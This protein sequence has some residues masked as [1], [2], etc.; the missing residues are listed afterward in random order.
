MKSEEHKIQVAVV[1]WAEQMRVLCPDLWMLYANPNGG[2][3]NPITGAMLK[4]EGTRR[5]IPDL[6]LAV[7]RHGFHGLYLEMK[8]SKGILSRDQK[9]WIEAL[10][11]QV[12]RVEV[13]RSVAEAIEVFRDYLDLKDLRQVK[14]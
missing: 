6:F 7:A 11:A 2:A 10:Q 4:A 9:A 12:Y 8:T 14:S 3:R 1:K 5:G 13:C